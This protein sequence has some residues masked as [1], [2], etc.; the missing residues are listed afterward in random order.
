[1]STECEDN[2]KG[3]VAEGLPVKYGNEFGPLIDLGLAANPSGAAIDTKELARITPTEQLA[4][5]DAKVHHE[6]IKELLLKGIGI[7]G[8]DSESVIFHPNGSYGAGDEIVRALGNYLELTHKKRPS[9]YV[10]SYSFPNVKQYAIRHRVNY[11]PLPKGDSL[12]QEDSLKTLLSMG[13]RELAGNIMYIDYPNNP[14]G[15]ANPDLLRKAVKHVKEC[16]GIPFVDM[17][18]G[19]V[20]G[21]EFR[22]A[23]QF[24]VDNGG[25]CVGS[26]TKTQGLP[27]LRAGYIILNKDLTNKL[28]NGDTRLVFGLPAHVKNAYMILFTKPENGGK[29]IAQLQSEK[30]IIYNART[31]GVF[32][33]FLSEI[34]I[35]KAPTK[36]E[37]P[38]Q[39][40]YKA[41]DNLFIRLASAGIKTECLDDYAG[42]LP[43]NTNGLG[44]SGI[45][46]LTPR[47]GQL[48]NTMDRIST[49][50]KFSPNFVKAKEEEAAILNE[51]KN[52]NGKR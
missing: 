5:Y 46:I 31:N 38:I 36:S 19:E 48:E 15:I 26:L 17:A 35:E 43:E 11:E 1:M 45:R 12:F 34:G 23:I 30:A 21:D 39:L 13:S 20:L 32:Y 33:K 50:M 14:T 29:N 2:A 51:Q 18:F 44:K 9:M 52:K 49:A 27:A 3:Y 24:T 6:D 22:K 16:D 40:L 47:Q 7:T 42:T 8:L 25:V 28:Y 10:T 4:E 41:N 37:T